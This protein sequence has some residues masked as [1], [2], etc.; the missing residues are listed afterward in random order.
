MYKCITTLALLGT[1]SLT[2]GCSS[3]DDAAGTGGTA[4]AGGSAGMGG[5]AG[6]G[7]S[8]GTG[9]TAGTN[10]MGGGLSCVSGVPVVATAAPNGLVCIDGLTDFSF[11]PFAVAYSWNECAACN[12]ETTVTLSH[13]ASGKL[14]LS[15]HVA[16][17]GLA[18]FNLELAR[19]AP[20]SEEILEAF[21]ADA[22]G[23]TQVAFTLDSPPSDGL[24]LY[25]HILR[26]TGCPDNQIN[27]DYP[28]NFV[29]PKLMQ[30]GPVIAPF[31]TFVS[32]DASVALDT[33]K[34]VN[35]LF[36][37]GPGDYDFCIRDFELLDD[38]GNAVNR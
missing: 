28:P 37:V 21:D 7:G 11:A 35:L 24:S 23:I 31:T 5:S 25:L 27:C 3:D 14:C 4:A 9:G 36:Q 18:G 15:G 38:D 6:S 10:D 19:R 29:F 17:G 16:D 33:Q 1:V 32:D 26:Q 12:A 34:L 8:G 13:P 20:D 30:A 2:A 22:R